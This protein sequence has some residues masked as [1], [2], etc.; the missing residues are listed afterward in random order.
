MTR[1][2]A[3]RGG[4][5]LA[6]ALGLTILGTTPAWAQ[7]AAA[8]AAQ[9]YEKGMSHYNL[10]R[11]D[12][13]VKEF[14]AAFELQPEPILLYNIAQAYRSKGTAEQA[15]F[16]YRRYLALEPRAK[17]RADIEKR[18]KELE[19][20]AR[21][22]AAVKDK[23]P[24]EIQ[25]TG[26]PTGTTP[27]PVTP[28]PPVV[29]PTP[30]PTPVTPTPVTPTPVTP[31]ETPTETAALGNTDTDTISAGLGTDT[32]VDATGEVGAPKRIRVSLAMGPMFPSFTSADPETQETL[33]KP[34]L[35]GLAATGSYGFP[36]GPVTLDAG[37]QFSLG[38]VPWDH[39]P[40]GGDTAFTGSSKLIGLVGGAA[41]RYPVTPKV[42][43]RGGLYGGITWWT[44]LGEG[45]PFTS[46]GQAASGAVP[47]PTFRFD[48]GADVKVWKDLY[49]TGG[50]MGS[51]ASTTSQGLKDRV[52][53]VRYI[54]VLVGVGYAL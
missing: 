35:F 20:I 24:T 34:T 11:F 52:S 6:L 32:G 28:T 21:R 48:I 47:M 3:R 50:I 13:A 17:N 25:P 1:L 54:D 12:D 26:K 45:N 10:G 53:G 46:S 41:A 49:V 7:D 15:I 16:F 27:T 14:S 44:G 31:T 39:T 37:A 18:I 4:R 5:A 22:Q 42:D 38:N 36:V 19:D 40:P 23:P 43:V 33:P 30:T 8:E 2:D 51:F 29:K 9:H